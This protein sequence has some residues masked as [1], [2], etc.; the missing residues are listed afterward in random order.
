MQKTILLIVAVV[1]VGCGTTG[2]V[3]DPSNPQNVFVEKVI[4]YK[5]KKPTGELTKAD[6]AKVTGLGSGDE[7]FDDG[8]Q[9]GAW[10]RPQITDEGLKE[11]AKLK[12]LEGLYLGHTKITDV[13]L[14]EVAKLQQLSKLGLVNTKITDA[15]LKDVSK[16]QQLGRIF[17][18][19]TKVTDAGVTEL[20]KA[21]PKC[22]IYK[23]TPITPREK[24]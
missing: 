5:L 21:L 19:G 20:K 11:V 1:M 24:P 13:G 18:T 3:S 12:Q 14:K 9:A 7:I 15:G 17:L 8:L 22:R 4:R 6:L 10:L 2:W 16:M 23:I